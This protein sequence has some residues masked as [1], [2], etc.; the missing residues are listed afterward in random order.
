M[1]PS[2]PAMPPA[3]ADIA[4]TWAYLEEGIDYIMNG[5]GST[6]SI[7]TVT[8]LLTARRVL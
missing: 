4:T 8:V 7:H 3:N 2:D 5:G 1:P 6:G